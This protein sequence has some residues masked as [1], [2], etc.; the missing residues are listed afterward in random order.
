MAVYREDEIQAIIALAEL[1]YPFNNPNN[2]SYKPFPKNMAEAQT[3]FRRFAVDLSIAFD[4][5]NE[6]GLVREERDG[7]FLTAAGKDAAIELRKL[8]PPIYYW[9]KDFYAAIEKSQ[10]F[11]TSCYLKVL[12]AQN[13]LINL[14]R[15][16]I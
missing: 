13:T 14:Q 2:N 16:L 12:G 7:W 4:S 8:R 10:A 3:Y 11:E 5:L 9:Y 1:S 6:K 15:A